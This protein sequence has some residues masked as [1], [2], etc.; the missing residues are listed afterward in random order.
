MRKGLKKCVAIILTIAMLVSVLSVSF[1]ASAA[2]DTVTINGQEFKVGDTIEV[3]KEITINDYWMLDSQVSVPYDNTVLDFVEGTEAEMFPMLAGHGLIWND[4]G[5]EIRITASDVNGIDFTNGG[6]LYTLKFSVISG[7]GTAVTIDEN[8]EEISTFPF[9]GDPSSDENKD[10]PI[11]PA[12]IIVVTDGSGNIDTS[13]G[14][15]KPT[16]VEDANSSDTLN[17]NGTEVSVDDTITLSKKIQVNDNWLMNGQFTVNYNPEYLKFA[18]ST[19]DEMFPNINSQLVYNDVK[20]AE[21]N[22][23]GEIIVTFT[24]FENGYDFTTEKYLYVLPFTVVKGS[25]DAQKVTDELQVMCSFNFPGDPATAGND[26]ETMVSVLNPDTNEIADGK[27]TSQEDPVVNDVIDNNIVINGE[28]YLPGDKINH[29]YKVQNACWIA[30]GQFEVIYPS[31]VVDFIVDEATYPAVEAAG[32][33][34]VYNVYDNQDG[35]KSVLF[36]FTAAAGGPKGID[37]TTAAKLFNFY[38]V[39]REDAPAGDY[40]I[41][42][43]ILEMYVYTTPGEPAE[44]DDKLMENAVEGDTVDVDYQELVTEL[45]K[46]DTDKLQKLIDEATA[47][48]PTGYTED[49]AKALADAIEQGKEALLDPTEEN[50]NAAIAALEAAIAGLTVDTAALEALVAQAEAIDTTGYTEATA[51]ALADAIAQGKE[52]LL[53]PTE[54]NVNAAITAIENAIKGLA[55]DTTDLEALIEE[56]E[57]IDTTGYTDDSAQALADAIAKAQAALEAPTVDGVKEAVE[58]LQVAK[59]GLTVDTAE[60]ESLIV[61]A[62]SVIENKDVYDIDTIE[63]LEAAIEA[64]EAVLEGN[65][66][67]DDV[68]AQITALTEALSGIK[69]DTQ[70]LRTAIAAVEEFEYLTNQ[71]YSPKSRAELSE[72]VNVGNEILERIKTEFVTYEEVQKAA[73][74]INTAINNLVKGVLLGNANRDDRTNINDVTWI[75]KYLVKI[76]EEAEIDKLAADVNKDKKVTIVD[77]TEIQLRLA[78]NDDDEYVYPDEV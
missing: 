30:N 26:D 7:S 42:T 70:A 68:N 46:I 16:V 74:D 69:P 19:D 4:T 71:I 21:D 78:A 34:V 32:I 54:E 6:V 33:K 3:T 52:A 36:N 15:E 45:S 18:P 53:D 63:T 8:L 9:P 76:I 2:E 24:D 48:D 59:D 5:D 66:S 65:P 1:V 39:V 10:K 47:I 55:V 14:S 49:S 72:K 50:V 17:V 27:G 73:D 28:T 44:F 25:K 51:K 61:K 41:N 60:L 23:T 37:M 11:D 22:S 12:D 62:N 58:A 43:D 40:T 20:D 77:A 31:D 38:F 75:Q 29:Y 35:T 57:A 56:A 13:K 64:A 67:I